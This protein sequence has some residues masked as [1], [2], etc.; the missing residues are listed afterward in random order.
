MPAP[1]QP[2]LA[3][4]RFYLNEVAQMPTVLNLPQYNRIT[5]DLSEAVL[6]EAERFARQVLSPLNTVGDK[7]GS[8]RQANGSVKTPDGFAANIKKQI[9]GA[10]PFAIHLR[11][12]IKKHQRF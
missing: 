2:D 6:S 9:K 10:E 12:R 8:K 7:Q 5:P 4:L 3:A 11:Q 1:F